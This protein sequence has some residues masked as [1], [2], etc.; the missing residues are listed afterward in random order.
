MKSTFFLFLLLV[1]GRIRIRTNN[2][3]SERP[4]NYGSGSTTLANRI[5]LTPE[6]SADLLVWNRTR[7]SVPLTYRSGFC[8]FLSVAGKMPTKKIVFFKVFC[9]LLFA[10]TFTSWNQRF[11]Y[12]FCLLMEGS[13][14][15]QIITD[16]G[17]QKHTDLASITLANRMFLTLERSADSP[18]PAPLQALVR[19]QPLPKLWSMEHRHFL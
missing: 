14:S 9:L 7:G 3:G 15:V 8:F 11:S 2:Y 12:F 1:D 4:K 5:F 10:G 18:V 19:A 17:G 6:R 16:P 13:R